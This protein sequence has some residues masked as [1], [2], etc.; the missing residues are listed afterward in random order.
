MKN[1]DHIPQQTI[2]DPAK[3]RPRQGAAHGEAVWHHEM[4][5]GR[6]VEAAATVRRM[7]MRI[8]PK[9]F[10]T[11]WP[12]FEA[13]T[14]GE[15]QALKNELQQAGQL[16]AWEREQN[17]IR[18]PPSG[19]EIERC[20]QALG[21]IPRYLSHDTETAQAVGFWASKTF[22]FNEDQIPGFVRSGLREISRGLRRDRVP[23]RA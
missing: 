5:G 23:V 2:V 6:L 13:M 11:A 10:G 7:P 15:L 16:E 17:R 12:H 4:V 14:A 22:D 3:V 1:Q 21:W 19:A 20:E 18:I 8:W 9:Q